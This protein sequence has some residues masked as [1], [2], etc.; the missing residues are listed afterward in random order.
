MA[1]QAKGGFST[2]GTQYATD[3]S[4]YLLDT[5]PGSGSVIEGPVTVT[6]NLTVT[7]SETVQGSL[8]V[9]G[10][11][12][13]PGLFA[14][15][16]AAAP[17]ALVGSTT[18]TG[19]VKISVPF[20][21][22]GQVSVEGGGSNF[23]G[24]PANGNINLITGS[25]PGTVADRITISNAGVGT[26]T[27]L[28]GIDI[29]G[30]L[31]TLNGGQG[32]TGNVR[33]INEGN[34]GLS[35]SNSG[36]SGLSITNASSG[37]TDLN[38]VNT[39]PTG[40]VYLTNATS[41]VYI[42]SGPAANVNVRIGPSAATGGGVSLTNGLACTGSFSAPVP[43]G[44]AYVMTTNKG[45]FSTDQAICVVFFPQFLGVG[46]AYQGIALIS[47][48]DGQAFSPVSVSQNGVSATFAFLPGGNNFFKIVVV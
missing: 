44:A 34:G 40:Q 12:T 14:P 6:N 43:I 32:G 10:N 8:G 15:P 48:I 5:V 45:F 24:L 27:Q 3:S 2:E 13:A 42:T 47:G 31:V 16:A 20:G 25:V 41:G 7:G 17:L 1:S 30:G 36:A 33:I 4:Y 28:N 46:T 22:T 11:I 26:L 18:F 23:L 35:L 29:S 38:I 21:A 39:N 19:G 37:F 9:A